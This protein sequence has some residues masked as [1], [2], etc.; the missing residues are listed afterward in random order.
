MKIRHTVV[1]EPPMTP[2][3]VVIANNSVAETDFEVVFLSLNDALE[4]QITRLSNRSRLNKKIN[5]PIQGELN[6]A[7][8]FKR[9][10]LS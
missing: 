1:E 2:T 9:S 3:I 10:F 8:T 5:Y 4:F 6:D 7:L